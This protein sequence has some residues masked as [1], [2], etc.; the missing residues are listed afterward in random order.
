MRLSNIERTTTLA[1]PTT[2][3]ATHYEGLT[4]LSGEVGGDGVSLEIFFAIDIQHRQAAVYGSWR[5]NKNTVIIICTSL[6]LATSAVFRRL[7]AGL[8]RICGERVWF[9]FMGREFDSFCGERAWF[10]FVGR[11]FD[12]YLWRDGLIPIC[13][14]MVWFLF[15]ARGFDSYLWGDA[16]SR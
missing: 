9:L 12:S 5:E 3:S 15:V 10:L 13:G 14:E 4:V 6:N 2:L 11:G 8:I 16:T 7:A 1:N